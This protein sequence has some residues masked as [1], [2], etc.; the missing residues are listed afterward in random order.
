MNFNRLMK[1][2]LWSMLACTFFGFLPLL[3]A[4]AVG[5][6]SGED[7]M[8]EA[9]GS[10]T[11]LWLMNISLPLSFILGIVGFIIFL[12]GLFKNRPPK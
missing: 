10:G 7:M 9:T 8:S 5:V 1:V 11:W 2:G 4:L 6:F 12:F 3:I